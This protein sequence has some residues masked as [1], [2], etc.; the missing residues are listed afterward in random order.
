MGGGHA[1]RSSLDTQALWAIRYMG[2]MAVGDVL[3]Y[4]SGNMCNH[5]MTCRG[6][7]PTVVSDSLVL[8]NT[9]RNSIR[10]EASQ[11][12]TNHEKKELRS[13]LSFLVFRPLM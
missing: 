3:G 7:L 4:Y 6:F 8:E 9:N 5:G 1:P 11:F 12:I 10:F 2:Y 13:S